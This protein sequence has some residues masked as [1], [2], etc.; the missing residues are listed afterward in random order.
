MM[1]LR[2]YSRKLKLLTFFLTIP[3]ICSFGQVDSLLA[4]LPTPKHDTVQMDL[5]NRLAFEYR[6]VDTDSTLFYANEANRL[7]T[8]YGDYKWVGRSLYSIGVG[9]H[10]KG[11]FDSAIFYYNQAI[12]LAESTND[13]TG[14]SS[15]Y[16]NL[17]L[18]DWN[19]GELI[20]AL[21]FFLQSYAIYERLQDSL[22]IVTSFNNIGLIYRNMG[23]NQEALDYF[24]KA[25][26][27]LTPQGS[28]FRLSQLH[29]NLGLTYNQL[30]KRD[31]SLFHYRKSLWYAKNAEA[32]CYTA[33]PLLGIADLF[34][35]SGDVSSDSLTLYGQKSLQIARNCGLPKI[36]SGALMVLGDAFFQ[37]MQWNR[38]EAQYKEALQLSTEFD[39]KE[40][41]KESHLRF[42]RLYKDQK[43]WK[44]ALESYEVYEEVKSRLLNEEKIRE[45]TL[46]EAQYE[47]EK[48]REV[49]LTKQENERLIY[50][51]ELEKERAK[52]TF[53]LILAIALVIVAFLLFLNYRR[54]KV[55]S[56]TLTKKN[57]L[58]EELSHFKNDLN[59]M[60]VHDIKNPLHSI[61]TISKGLEQRVGGSIVKASNVILRLITNMLD[62]EKLEEAKPHLH[63]E[64]VSLVE[65]ISDAEMAVNLL[66][67]E[68]SIVLK[69]A[70]CYD[71]I[72]KVDRELIT[73][74][75]VNLL[76][77][78]I[79]YSDSN[80][81]ITVVVE[82]E[83]A[84]QLR[85][86]IQD[87][88]SGIAPEDLP[89]IFEKYYQR[90][91][92]KSGI[93][94]STGLGLAF[95]KMAIDAHE[96]E[97]KVESEVGKGTTFW[98][99][100]KA[101]SIQERMPSAREETALVLSNNEKE[102]LESYSKSLKK[103]KVHNVR[104]IMSILDEIEELDIDSTW[105][106]QLR[107]AVQYSN[108]KQ[109][110]NLLEMIS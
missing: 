104:S 38:A 45:I 26:K 32:A 47:S 30:E 103:L 92:R 78:A 88:G 5:L 98:V 109:Y 101:L 71:A 31:S 2:N 1:S 25:E 75:F 106:A 21:E 34:A 49:L 95:C 10:I 36:Q 77:N 59:H 61:I 22:G 74:V 67:E 39:I 63:P 44:E 14:L 23:E 28:D 96:G 68:K 94:P 42:Y 107:S 85:I 48:E 70:M 105:P 6:V 27:I 80:S 50:E 24:L 35:K 76:S 11:A 69:N 86:G 20:S 33:H 64:E 13:L 16:N 56:A 58:I 84:M 79:K 90:D 83:K 7:A 18:V 46:L 53:Y 52:I 55:T 41:V 51:K 97:L 110:K 37:E 65:I 40:N 60:I 102:K 100:L 54:E 93:S 81:Q 91:A 66:L 19:K 62:I 87:D 89:H 9:H 72:L 43:R 73:R 8:K 99:N 57:N 4:D 12:P 15:V 29:N 108:K 17:G 82:Q 3:I